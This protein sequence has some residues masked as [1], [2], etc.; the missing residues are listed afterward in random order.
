MVAFSMNAKSVFKVLVV[1]LLG[2]LFVSVSSHYFGAAMEGDIGCFDA[3]SHQMKLGQSLY[4]DV[5]DNKAPGIFYI[6]YLL[7]EFGFSQI[8]SS[9]IVQ[10]LCFFLLLLTLIPILSQWMLSSPIF[11]FCA[12]MFVVF[13]FRTIILFWPA[14]FVGGYTEQIGSYLLISGF[15]MLYQSSVFWT[16]SLESNP[17]NSRFKLIISGLLMGLTILIKEPFVFFIPAILLW[18]FFIPRKGLG[19]WI[20]GFVSPWILHAL[21]LFWSGSYQDYIQYLRFAMNYGIAGG[22]ILE[23]QKWIDVL[24]PFQFDSLPV[25]NV[26]QLF[27]FSGFI[28]LLILRWRQRKRRIGDDTEVE[29]SPTLIFL[30]THLLL[31]WGSRY[32]GLLG[33][34]SYLHYQIPEYLISWL[35]LLSLLNEFSIFLKQYSTVEISKARLLFMGI[36]AILYLSDSIVKSNMPTG[37]FNM[38]QTLKN[39]S[40]IN[41]SYYPEL[42]KIKDEEQTWNDFLAKNKIQVPEKSKIFIDDPHLGRFYGYLNSQYATCFPCPYW[43]Y[44]HRDNMEVHDPLWPFLEQNRNKIIRQLREQPPQFV[45]MSENK[46]PYATFKELIDFFE[47]N[48]EKQGDFI[49]GNKKVALYKRVHSELPEDNR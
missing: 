7:P 34:R 49:L 14:F 3:I 40:F 41:G 31:L 1:L 38:F 2:C 42:P 12:S 15:F 36:A 22:S 45:M 35:G 17:A 18:L 26:I 29:K 30:F 4:T 37:H 47:H 27:V 44:F 13:S 16:N 19:L 43:V 24:I 39:P 9:W 8:T 33:N 20:L 46:G 21:I 32:F 48:F 6:N 28:L 23:A 25:V 5:Y 10:V 11:G